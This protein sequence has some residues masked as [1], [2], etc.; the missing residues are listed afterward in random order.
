[1]LAVESQFVESALL[2]GDRVESALPI[3]VAP[4]RGADPKS[5][6]RPKRRHGSETPQGFHDRLILAFE[7]SP[8]R[9]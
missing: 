9:Q 6:G 8:G 5:A 7:H 1:M 2:T 3:G 4:A